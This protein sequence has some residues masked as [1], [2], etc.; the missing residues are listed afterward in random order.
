MKRVVIT[1]GDINGIGPEIIVKSLG[2]ITGK[3]KIYLLMPENIFIDA[4]TFANDNYGY[5]IVSDY[6][7]ADHYNTESV[8]VISTGKVIKKKIGE[9]TK[10]S[11]LTSYNAIEKSFHYLSKD[12]ADA[13]VTA[14]ISKNSFAMAGIK[15]P[16]HTELYASRCGIKDFV[17]MFISK[18]M[19]AAILTIHNPL[20][21]VPKII[22]V[23]KIED[24]IKTIIST[25]KND[26]SI[27]EPR[28]AVLGLNPH[29]GENGRIGEE[30][31]KIISPAIKKM[32]KNISVE[33]PFPSD[34]FF[35][36]RSYKN[37]DITLGMYHD[38]ILIPFKLLNFGGGINFTAG[39]P[40]VRTSPDHGTAYDIA[41]QGKADERSFIEAY[42]L[43]LKIVS[44]RKKKN[45]DTGKAI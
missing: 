16:G 42:N 29:A 33:G 3:N 25:L 4:L 38:Q 17:M 30:E 10:I 11:G 19:K 15:F 31:I 22:S 34:G 43:A 36:N 45:S 32:S 41:W 6:S 27:I 18:N 37:Y 24:T 12:F 13:V 44:N 39:L 20:K 9:P 7:H 40:I 14:P 35:A 1:C 26:F 5:E 21:N 2:K 28:I 8:S 23:G